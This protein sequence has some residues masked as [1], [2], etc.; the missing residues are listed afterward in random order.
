ME[1]ANPEKPTS[2]PQLC[3]P[4]P[5]NTKV[6]VWD[7]FVRLSH[8]SLALAFAAA[9]ISGEEWRGFHLFAGYAAIL[10]IAGRLVWGFAGSEHARFGDFVKSPA[11]VADYVRDVVNRRDGRYIGHNPAGGLMVMALLALVAAVSISGLLL[12]TDAFWGSDAMDMIH[13]A[14]AD[15]TL[16]FI[17]AHIFGV[18]FTSVRTRENLVWSMVSGLKRPPAAREKT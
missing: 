1:T 3:N 15:V 13:G 7:L 11:A 18:A 17:A 16:F 5:N 2:T 9:Y 12:T 14:L 10:L 4:S 8:W 6:K